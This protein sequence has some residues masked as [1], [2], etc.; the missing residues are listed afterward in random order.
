[1]MSLPREVTPARI[2]PL[3]QESEQT[4]YVKD[5]AVYGSA[6]FY[7]DVW[8]TYDLGAGRNEQ[9][10]KVTFVK[11]I[12]YPVR[13]SPVAQSADVHEGVRHPG[14]VSGTNDTDEDHDGGV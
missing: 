4:A 12:C 7:P 5:P 8:F 14:D 10:V 11:V 9:N 1:M 13:Y 2:V 6:A 3:S